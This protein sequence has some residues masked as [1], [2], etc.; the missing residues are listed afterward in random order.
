[1]AFQTNDARQFSDFPPPAIAK[2]SAPVGLHMEATYQLVGMTASND[3]RQSVVDNVTG[4]AEDYLERTGVFHVQADP[5]S[6]DYNLV[7]RIRDDADPNV[8]L[9]FLTGLTLYI[10]PSTA[11]DNF[12]T[13]VELI[14]AAGNQIAKKRFKHQVKVVQQLF[15]ILGA[16]FATLNSKS[17][18]MWREVLQDVSVWAAENVAVKQRVGAMEERGLH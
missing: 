1:M 3:L 13:D 16:P 18:Q 2:K 11:S 5:G 10:L 9:A 15:L 6:A 17:E 14:D 12:T 7:I 4:W 8:G